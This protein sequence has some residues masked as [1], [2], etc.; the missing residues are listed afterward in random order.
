M[1]ACLIVNLGEFECLFM[2]P[3]HRPLYPPT[4]STTI[5]QNFDRCIWC[6]KTEQLEICLRETEAFLSFHV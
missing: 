4:N 1:I 5:G 3:C 6:I 2:L